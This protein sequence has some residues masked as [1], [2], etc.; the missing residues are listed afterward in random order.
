[1]VFSL[2]IKDTCAGAKT[3]PQTGIP[4]AGQGCVRREPLLKQVSQTPKEEL[5][6]VE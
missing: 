4:L 3:S 6:N 2:D 1:V 5:I